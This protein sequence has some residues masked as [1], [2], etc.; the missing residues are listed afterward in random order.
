M[1]ICIPGEVP[2][3]PDAYENIDKAADENA[4][5]KPQHSNVLLYNVATYHMLTGFCVVL[6]SG[7]WECHVFNRPQWPHKTT[8]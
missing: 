4:H 3:S 1:L 5:L 7:C 2:S 6:N 8:G